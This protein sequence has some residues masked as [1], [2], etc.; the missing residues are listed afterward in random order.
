MEVVPRGAIG[1]EEASNDR[2]FGNFSGDLK[3]LV[4]CAKHDLLE[5]TGEQPTLTHYLEQLKHQQVAFS[6]KQKC[7]K[8]VDEVVTA[9]LEMESYLL[10]KGGTGSRRLHFNRATTVSRIFNGCFVASTTLRG[11]MIKARTTRTEVGMRRSVG[12]RISL[13]R[14]AYDC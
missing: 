14:I 3:Q 13:E 1:T 10:P 4:E 6:V 9:T 2:R 12:Q 7:P 11:P 8:T 5:D